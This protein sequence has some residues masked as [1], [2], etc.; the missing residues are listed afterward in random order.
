MSLRADLLVLAPELIE[1]TDAR[2]D[3]FLGWAALRINRAA[4]ASKADLGTILLAAHMLTRFAVDSV[5][6]VSGPV[7]QEKVGDLEARYGELKIAGSEEL[8]TTTYGAQF[9][10]MR[11]AINVTPLIV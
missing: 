6:G 10:Q 3:M 4:W 5:A 1:E 8:S 11:R 2:I 7:I 9:A